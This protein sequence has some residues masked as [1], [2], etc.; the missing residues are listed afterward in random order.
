MFVDLHPIGWAICQGK[1]YSRILR[2]KFDSSNEMYEGLA[3]QRSITSVQNVGLSS[4]S[5]SLHFLSP[6]DFFHSLLFLFPLLGLKQF[7]QLLHLFHC[8]CLY[9]FKGLMQFFFKDIYHLHK[10]G[11]KIIFLCFTYDGTARVF[12][13]KASVAKCCQVSQI[14]VECV[15]RLSSSYLKFEII[16]GLYIDFYICNCQM[17][18]FLFCFVDVFIPLISVSSRFSGVNA[19]RFQ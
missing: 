11:F 16:T 15:L 19:L 18:G 3:I 12:Y 17:H 2:G 7:I 1:L 4:E 10:I 13:S 5:H 9:F 8:A 6:S 14:V